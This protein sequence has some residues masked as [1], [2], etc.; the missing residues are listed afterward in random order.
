MMTP[1][2]TNTKTMK[3]R[4]VASNATI[5][6]FKT[7]RIGS[8]RNSKT[9][10]KENRHVIKQSLERVSGPSSAKKNVKGTF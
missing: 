7:M 3:G 10:C 2:P 9:G 8:A 1:L 6:C 4:F 5:R